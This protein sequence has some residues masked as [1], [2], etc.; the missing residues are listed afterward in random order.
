VAIDK[1]TAATIKDL[2]P[3]D[4][5]HRVS[6]GAQLF[7]VVAPSGSKRWVCHIQVDGKRATLSRHLAGG[8]PSR[9]RAAQ[10]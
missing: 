10:S 2:K 8:L 4:K 7:Q 6:D 1:L 9:G 3:K 5:G